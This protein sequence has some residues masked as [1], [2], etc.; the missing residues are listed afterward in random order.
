M[1]V[2]LGS[3]SSTN[4]FSIFAT[5]NHTNVFANPLVVL[6]AVLSTAL[7]GGGVILT[8]IFYSVCRPKRSALFSPSLD[9]HHALFYLTQRAG[10]SLSQFLTER[11]FCDD[12]TGIICTS[13]LAPWTLVPVLITRKTSAYYPL[14]LYR[15][16]SAVWCDSESYVIGSSSGSRLGTVWQLMS[17]LP[18]LSK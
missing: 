15:A 2:H 9:R 7:F 12:C 13:V 1:F 17:I 14:W 11:D 8:S 5:R 6:L 4:P 18:F 3:E 10:P 16:E